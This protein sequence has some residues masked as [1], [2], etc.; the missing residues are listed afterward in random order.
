MKR[1][2]IHTV[3][4]LTKMTEEEMGRIRNLGKKSIDE[5]V[6]KLDSLGVKLK[7]KED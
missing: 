3:E 6:L 1:G 5:I 7:D 4:D 2:S